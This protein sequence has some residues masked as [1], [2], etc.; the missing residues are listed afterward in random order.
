[1]K[2]IFLRRIDNEQF[3]GNIIRWK[4]GRLEVHF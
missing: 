3:G 4:Q 2:G 1:M